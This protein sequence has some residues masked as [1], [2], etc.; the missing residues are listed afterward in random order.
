VS[1]STQT[2][3][4]LP[5]TVAISI[6]I[7]RSGKQNVSGF[8]CDTCPG[9]AITPV[10]TIAGVEDR[11]RWQLTH[12][13]SGCRLVPLVFRSG[14][15][16]QRAAARIAPLADWRA[17]KETFTADVETLRRQLLAIAAEEGAI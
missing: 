17:S 3:A 8:L 14:L 7:P 4:W 10:W 2:A 12:V 1:T 16:A 9:I 13:E 11:T 6:L 5:A 15:E